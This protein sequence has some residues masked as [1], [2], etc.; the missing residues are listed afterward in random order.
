MKRSERWWSGSGKINLKYKR[1][2]AYARVKYHIYASGV[3]ST[4]NSL[5]CALITLSLYPSRE[6]VIF[7]PAK[8]PKRQFIL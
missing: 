5:V 2:Q 4:L 6:G 1:T 8:S 3:T 7:Y